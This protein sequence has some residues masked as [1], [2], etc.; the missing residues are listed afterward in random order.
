MIKNKRVTEEEIRDADQ[1]ILNH[2]LMTVVNGF[3][4]LLMVATTLIAS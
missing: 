1:W 2:N 3:I 4:L